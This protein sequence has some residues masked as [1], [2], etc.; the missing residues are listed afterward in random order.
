MQTHPA[1]RTIH[2]AEPVFCPACSTASEEIAAIG[3][4]TVDFAGS[5]V[6]GDA[7]AICSACGASAPADEWPTWQQ[8]AEP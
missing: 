8:V 4:T 7:D 6:P 3:R 2:P 5:P 1:P